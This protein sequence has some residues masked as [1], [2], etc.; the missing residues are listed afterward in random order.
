MKIVVTNRKAKHNYQIIETHEAGV[1][2]RGNEVKSLRTKGCSIEEGFVRIEWGEVFLYNVH[3][4]DFEKSSFF[5]SD[6]KR[7]RKL[8]MHKKEIKRLMGLTAQKGL[9][10]VPLKIYFNDRGIAKTEIALVK[11]R[12]IFDKR[13]KLKEKIS[14]KETDRALKRFYKK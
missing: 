14:K 3:I 5:K 4:P 9:T 7:V 10:I 6:P 1:E 2:F 8:L 12:R 13:K 11:G